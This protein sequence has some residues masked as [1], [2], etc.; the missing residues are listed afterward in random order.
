MRK[1]VI[2]VMGPGDEARSEDVSRAEILGQLI[3]NKGWVVLSGGR[4]SGVMDAVNRGASKAGGLTIGILPYKD[5][6]KISAFVD[7]P[8]ITDMGSGRNNINVLS[9]DVVVACGMG[10]GTASEVALAI[11]GARSVILLGVGS[12][13][14]KFFSSL[15]E[16]LVQVARTPEEAI[17]QIE[18]RLLP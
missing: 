1:I 8:I 12:E 15:D 6:S 4:N 14:E 18:E 16:N 3:A 5:P 11:K 7:I 10:S 9:S 13:A 17:S 2:G